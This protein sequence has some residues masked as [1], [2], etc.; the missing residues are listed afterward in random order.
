MDDRISVLAFADGKAYAAGYTGFFILDVSNPEQPEIISHLDIPGLAYG[1]SLYAN[2][3][4]LA[5]YDNY[6]VSLISAMQIIRL[7]L[8]STKW[9]I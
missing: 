7:W 5:L 4:Y 8:L 3:A 6:L 1:V 9:N 2:F